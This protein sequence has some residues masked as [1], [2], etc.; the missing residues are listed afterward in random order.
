MHDAMQVTAR[1]AVLEPVVAS[2]WGGLNAT[3]VPSYRYL[4]VDR[5]SQKAQAS[6]PSKVSVPLS[7]HS[8]IGLPKTSTFV[9]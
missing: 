1:I 4:H 8:S 7:C 2:Q 3:H 9:F 6:P 5:F